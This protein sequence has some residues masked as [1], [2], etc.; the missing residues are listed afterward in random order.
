MI[1]QK[2]TERAHLGPS[3]DDDERA[4]SGRSSVKETAGL[5]SL[6]RSPPPPIAGAFGC[7]FVSASLFRESAHWLPHEVE[8]CAISSWLVSCC[9]LRG[10]SPLLLLIGLP[11]GQ[12][13]NAFGTNNCEA[14]AAR[15]THIRLA[16]RSSFLSGRRLNWRVPA[17]KNEAELLVI[18]GSSS[19]SGQRSAGACGLRNTRLA[20]GGTKHFQGKARPRAA[21]RPCV[22]I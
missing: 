4:F 3:I 5:P 15:V 11:A 14:S 7:I 2:E 21:P 8:F 12:Q 1:T 17:P 9:V 18:A 19:T 20:F 13:P 6:A 16:G 22:G 10:R